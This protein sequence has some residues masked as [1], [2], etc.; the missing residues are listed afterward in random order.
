MN[1]EFEKIKTE[2]NENQ[3]RNS[4]RGNN[5]ELTAKEIEINGRI[6][7]KSCAGFIVILTVIS[8]NLPSVISWLKHLMRINQQQ[9]RTV[10]SIL[11]SLIGLAYLKGWVNA[12]ELTLESLDAPAVLQR[13]T[14]NK[15]VKWLL[16][17]IGQTYK[18]LSVNDGLSMGLQA[19]A[20]FESIQDELD[21][22]NELKIEGLDEKIDVEDL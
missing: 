18:Q 8:L 21:D 9:K 19:A 20:L 4:N 11:C 1:R 3:N 22:R 12:T 14:K 10:K 2:K 13:L 15:K 7:R 16:N 6:I 17:Y 5:W